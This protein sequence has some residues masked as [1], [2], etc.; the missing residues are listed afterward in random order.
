M[1]QNKTNADITRRWALVDVF[2]SHQ[3]IQN[4]NTIV[5][6]DHIKSLNRT[7]VSM[8]EVL[9]SIHTTFKE[10]FLQYIEYFSLNLIYF[11]FKLLWTTLPWIIWHKLNFFSVGDKIIPSIINFI[12]YFNRI[13]I[14]F[15]ETRG[16]GKWVFGLI[17]SR[18]W[19]YS[20]L[21]LRYY[22]LLYPDI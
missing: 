18:F 19:D 12:F 11:S 3:T 9:I 7:C 8:T 6:I 1:I 13:S 14:F 16:W 22:D 4:Y 21:W 20:I 15:H 5:T 17:S 2:I 10:K